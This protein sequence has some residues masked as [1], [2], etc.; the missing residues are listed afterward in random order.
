[1][2]AKVKSLI[3]EIVMIL[4]TIFLFGIIFGMNVFI[5]IFLLLIIGFHITVRVI[6]NEV[7]LNGLH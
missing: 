5:P 7:L 4:I 3:I 6:F 1:M 2:T